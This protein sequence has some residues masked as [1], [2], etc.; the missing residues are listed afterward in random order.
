MSPDERRDG[1]RY[2]VL[3]E[4]VEQ[5]HREGYVH[6]KGVVSPTELAQLEAVYMRFLRR[7]IE[8][9]GKDFCDMSG[10]Y[11]REVDDFSIINVML[12]RR[13]HPPWRDNIYEQRA[14]SIAEQ[15]RGAGMEIDYDQLLAK[16]PGRDDGIFAWH[17]DMAYWTATR[18]P[19]TASLW[20]ALDDSTEENG[21][22]RFVARSHLEP[23]LRP[24][25]PLHGDRSKSHTLVTDVDEEREDI[26]HAT[27]S[28][29]DVTVHHERIVH[30]S[31]PNRSDGWRRAYIVALRSRE[32]VAD[33][34][35]RGF[36]HSHNDGADVLDSVGFNEPEP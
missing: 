30:G 8:V 5:F 3:P 10:D 22:L 29:G 15:L 28:A 14:C 12:P 35:E 11:G 13:Y 6:L 1:P 23:E 2:R 20:L 32:T 27:I 36:T 33:E 17:Q 9:R 34:R 19:R 21:C 16:R 18:D 7:E 24:H 26:R 25:R 4:E 31:G